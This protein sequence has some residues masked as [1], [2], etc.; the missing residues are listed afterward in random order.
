VRS[1]R[2]LGCA[3]VALQACTTVAPPAPLPQ[4]MEGLGVVVIVPSQ[5]PPSSNFSTFAKGAPAG[6]VKGAAAFGGITAGAVLATAPAMGPYA[7]LGYAL[8]LIVV[9]AEAAAGA[10]AG[11]IWAVPEATAAQI[12]AVMDDAVSKLDAQRAF[13][14]KLNTITGIALRA[15]PLRTAAV[16]PP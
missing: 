7:P 3:A 2:I 15:D 14:A 11:S 16:T 10:V 13:A 4:V 12:Q 9:A 5:S 6:A 1:L 8:G